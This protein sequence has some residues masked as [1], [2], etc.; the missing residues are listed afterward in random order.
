MI[1][2]VTYTNLC[3][4]LAVLYVYMDQEDY[5]ESLVQSK[6]K[7]ANGAQLPPLQTVIVPYAVAIA[8]PIIQVV[9]TTLRTNQCVHDIGILHMYASTKACGSD[10]HSS[11]AVAVIAVQCNRVLVGT[12]V[13]MC[14]CTHCMPQFTCTQ[15]HEQQQQQVLRRCRVLPGVTARSVTDE[16]ATTVTASFSVTN[17]KDT[18]LR[19]HPY[20]ALPLR[21]LPALVR[22]QSSVLITLS[23][24]L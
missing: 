10:D 14:T 24:L 9:T 2:A 1:T 17:T 3:C 16:T 5:A 8:A 21:V 4:L 20:S 13:L 12:T 7:D 23:Q 11:L 19:L 18:P 15:E 22:M 6:L